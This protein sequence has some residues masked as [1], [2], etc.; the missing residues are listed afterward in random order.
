LSPRR[1]QANHEVAVSLPG[2][3]VAITVIVDIIAPIFGIVLIGYLAA[4]LQAFDEAAARGLSLFAFNF[5]IPVMLVRTLAR[6]ELPAQ[7]EWGLVLAYFGGAFLIF[8]IAAATAR[9][10]FGRR[11]ADPAIFGISAAFSNT[12]ILGIPLVLEA[13]GESA[14]VPL[15][16]IMAF[17]SAL[18]FTATTIVAEVGAGAGAPLKELP[19]NVG[20]GLV[21]NPILWGI[22]T[23]LV[24]NLAGLALPPVLDRLAAILGGAALPAALFALGANLSRFRLAGSL[25]EALLLSGL[26]ILVQPALVYLLAAWMFAL[27]P[28]SLAVAVTIA[29]LPSGINA[30]LFAARYQAGVPE[31]SSTILV[32]TLLSVVTLSLLLATLRG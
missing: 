29:A 8:A 15:S 11:G 5:A 12:I 1:R 9:R 2:G 14:A 18:L 30:Y 24:L 26:K 21:G 22:G 16:L 32:S 25:R 3:Y 31:A 23:G 6:A 7:P 17:H 4:R 27:Q 20:R 28:V 13:F 10:L 19:R